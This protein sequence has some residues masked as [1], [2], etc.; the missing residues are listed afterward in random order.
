MN[1]AYKFRIYPNTEQAEVIQKTFGCC[2]FVYNYFLAERKKQWE[3]NGVTL[4]YCACS[5]MLTKLKQDI[6]WL[7][8]PDKYALGNSLRD[9]DRAYQNFFNGRKK[10]NSVGYP[11]FKSKKEQRKSYRT[12]NH[13]K[14][15]A[16][17]IVGSKIKLPKLGYV[18]CRISR[19]QKG[20]ILNATI[21]QESVGKYFV[22]LCCEIEQQALPK[23]NKQVGVDVGIKTLAT[24]SDGTKYENHK[25]LHKSQKRLARLQRQLSRKSKDSKH[26]EKARIAVAKLHE[27]IANQRKDTIHKVTT[28]IVRSYDLICV[29]DLNVQDMFETA[30]YKRLRR[31][32]SDTAMGEFLRVL[33]YKVEMYD[34]KMVEVATDYPSSQICCS[35]GKQSEKLK[36]SGI[37]KWTCP[38][39]GAVHDR[40]INAAKNILNEG[41]RLLQ[42]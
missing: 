21:L 32:M 40:D 30:K 22:V 16:I 18:K 15:T 1:A 17:V 11:K 26:R 28:D 13:N 20:R 41:L 37:R 42:A 31:S 24:L 14:N 33:T 2:R 4:N 35:C 5:K 10:S 9:L 38:K 27:H 6:E 23:T 7:R 8:E 3:E 12:N 34:K 19:Q 39:C 36:D 25:Y 29:E